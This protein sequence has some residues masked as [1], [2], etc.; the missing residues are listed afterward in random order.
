MLSEGEAGIDCINCG[1]EEVVTTVKE[2]NELSKKL[3]WSGGDP[4]CPG[5]GNSVTFEHYLDL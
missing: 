4:V 3:T 1:H 2:A 5:C